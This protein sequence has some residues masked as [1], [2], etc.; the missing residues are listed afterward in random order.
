MIS[1]FSS[2]DKHWWQLGL[3]VFSPKTVLEAITAALATWIALCS[4]C[5]RQMQSSG[6]GFDIA[7]GLRGK[8]QNSANDLHCYYGAI[9]VSSHSPFSHW[10]GIWPCFS[11]PGTS[12]SEILLN[13]E[14]WPVQRHFC[15]HQ[16][17][18]CDR[19]EISL[20]LPPSGCIPSVMLLNFS[21][22][23]RQR[24]V[25]MFSCKGKNSLGSP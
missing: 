23:L 22:P 3:L 10:A 11:Q 20:S 24:G 14:Q 18:Q 17:F 25:M 12:G 7:E 8:H 5:H 13:C 2:S 1:A 21:S 16:H 4:L 15:V 9:W 19:Q 6:A